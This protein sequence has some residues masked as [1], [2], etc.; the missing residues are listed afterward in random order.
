MKEKTAKE[1]FEKLGYVVGQSGKDV[2]VY[3]DKETH[4]IAIDFLLEEKWYAVSLN[5]SEYYP[6]DMQLNKAI[7]KQIKELQWDE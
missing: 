2:I 5:D 7:Q 1:M 4:G 6:I 3:Y